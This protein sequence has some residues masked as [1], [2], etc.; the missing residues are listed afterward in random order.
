MN[1]SPAN[2]GDTQYSSTSRY[3]HDKPLRIVLVAP[4]YFDLPPKGYGGIEAVVA[5]L[6]DALVRRGHRVTL[7]GAGRAKTSARFI[8]LWDTLQYPRLGEPYPEILHALRV[9]EAIAQLAA[10]EGIDVVHD[11]TFAGPLNCAAYQA[12]GA[13]V[14][15]T[16][17]GPVD[18]ELADYYRALGDQVHLVAI[19]DRQ[20]ELA[21]DLNWVGRVHN[22]L[23]PE[24]WPFSDEKKN[25]ALFLGRYSP[26][27]GPDLALRA[28]HEA[29]IPLIL[30]G[31]CNE[32]MEKAYFEE[33]VRPL[34]TDSDEVFGE[35]DAV[36]KR[37]LLASAR[38]MLFP[39]QWE[40]PFGI[41]MIESMVCGTPVV[42]L[43]RG[44]V[45]EVIV[46]GVTGVICD[47]PDQLPAAIAWADAIN[48]HECRAHVEQNF[49]ATGLGLG[50]E[51]AFR[52]ILSAHRPHVAVEHPAQAQ[53]SL[54][55]AMAE[56]ARRARAADGS[57]KAVPASDRSRR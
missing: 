44:S 4:P 48:P 13:V 14:V 3:S 28:A 5:D 22:A 36:A 9:R 40:E 47:H 57:P 15:A 27:K 45:P 1:I 46:D 19:S 31:K 6:A 29:G 10:E 7:L 33:T 30:A 12:A 50:Y 23:R 39:V 54:A 2:D 25:Y 34:L 38:C 49:A 51:Q 41:V 35:A 26:E 17:H 11:H 24:E 16:T 8:P 43:R 53:P 32:P 18:S 56:H 37:E 52:R 21:P 20:Q 42:A 55:R